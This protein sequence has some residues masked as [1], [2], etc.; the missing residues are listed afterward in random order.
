MRGRPVTT[1]PRV[2]ST[3]SRNPKLVASAGW[4]SSSPITAR[5]RK[6]RPRPGRPPARATSP[7][8]PITAAR[9]TLA[10]GPT[11]STKSPSPARPRTAASARLN[12]R[13]R[14]ASS[15]TPRIRLQLAPLTAVRWV[16]PTVF[17]AASSS[18]SREL[19]SPVTMPGRRPRASPSKCPA[20]AVKSPRSSAG[21]AA[22]ARPP[23]RPRRGTCREDGRFGLARL[24]RR[25]LPVVRSRCP[26]AACSQPAPPMTSR[27][28]C[29]RRGGQ[30]T[31]ISIRVAGTAQ[32]SA[33]P[34]RPGVLSRRGAPAISTST[35]TSACAATLRPRH[36][37]AAG[38]SPPR[39]GRPPPRRGAGPRPWSPRK[40]ASGAAAS[41]APCPPALPRAAAGRPRSSSSPEPATRARQSAARPRGA[42]NV[43]QRP[44]PTPAA[45]EGTRRTSVL[46]SCSSRAGVARSGSAKDA[47]Q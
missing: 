32:R 39:R 16:I 36:R 13:L 46:R 27:L 3:E 7:M 26:G 38:T 23:E 17:M 44:R 12:R 19:V 30:S 11:I 9:S 14:A 24:G 5:H 18:A 2:A 34:E 10:S 41:P 28:A 21:P 43:P 33:S 42:G 31:C 35:A 45:A 37:R 25:E 47:S 20:A 8:A 29:A 22:R 15:R 6:L 4:A 1:M 40:L